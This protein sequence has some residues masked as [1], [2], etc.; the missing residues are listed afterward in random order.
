MLWAMR[1]ACVLWIVG[2]VVFLTSHTIEQLYAGRLIMGLGIGQFGVLAPV[3]L[4]EVA[5]RDMRGILIGMFGMSEYLGIM[6]GV[7]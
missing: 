1:Q 3:Y 5:P 4:G 6:T 2:S 7:C